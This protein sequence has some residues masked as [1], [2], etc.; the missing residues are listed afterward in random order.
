MCRRK[1]AALGEGP[2]AA[3]AYCRSMGNGA[4]AFT[5]TA[6]MPLTILLA[7]G[8]TGPAASAP[9]VDMADSLSAAATAATGT[10]TEL[11][12]KRKCIYLVRDVQRSGRIYTGQFVV[13]RKSG[14]KLLG[15]GGAF[16]SEYYD[17]RGRIIKK[18]NRRY[19]RLTVSDPIDKSV[20]E[21]VLRRWVASKQKLAG[22]SKVRK[23]KVRKYSG[24]SI[25][26]P[27]RVC[28]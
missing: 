3:W 2:W 19:A 9:E 8:L 20:S 26:F 13:L 11:R 10:A 23:S 7:V 16:Y 25:P 17:L 12:A 5:R 28:R 18:K 4:T 14:K 6:T 22:W 24:G 15:Y 27:K 1:P 21:T